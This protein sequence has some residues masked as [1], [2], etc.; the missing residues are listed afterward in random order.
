MSSSNGRGR[1]APARRSRNPV[2]RL[3]SSSKFL[4]V[5]AVIAA[6]FGAVV[7]GKADGYDAAFLLRWVLAAWLISVAIED[8]AKH[9]AA[10]SR[11]R[12]ASTAMTITGLSV[13]NAAPAAEDIRATARFDRFELPEEVESAATSARVVAGEEDG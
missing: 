6:C 11:N 7:A 2:V 8:A 5:L 3:F 4:V 9:N 13:G 10:G 1:S 12:T